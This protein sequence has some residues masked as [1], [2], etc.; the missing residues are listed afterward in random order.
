MQKTQ[1]CIVETRVYYDQ[2]YCPLQSYKLLRD[3]KHRMSFCFAVINDW[4]ENTIPENHRHCTV[5]TTQ[6]HFLLIKLLY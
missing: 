5:H 4:H 3:V 2:I 6:A 1:D